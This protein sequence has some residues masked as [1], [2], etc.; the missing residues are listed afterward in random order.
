[1]DSNKTC[2]VCEGSR[3]IR[4]VANGLTVPCY[5]CCGL[6][7]WEYMIK[8]DQRYRDRIPTYKKSKQC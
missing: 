5:G 3:E 8:V 2:E 7:Y 1:M 6:S 4:D